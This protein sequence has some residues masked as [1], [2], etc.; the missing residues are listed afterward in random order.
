MLKH[1]IVGLEQIIELTNN[2]LSDLPAD[3]GRIATLNKVTPAIVD[4]HSCDT[5]YLCDM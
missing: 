4:S 2:D 5:S 3:F 1:A